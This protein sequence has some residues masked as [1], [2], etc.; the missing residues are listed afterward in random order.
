MPSGT[1]SGIRTVSHI[2]N[3]QTDQLLAIIQ[4]ISTVRSSLIDFYA[5]SDVAQPLVLKLCDTLSELNKEKRI[6]ID[7]LGWKEN[8]NE[9]LDIHFHNLEVMNQDFKNSE[10]TF[11]HYREKLVLLHAKKTT[12]ERGKFRALSGGELERLSRVRAFFL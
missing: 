8:H 10:K 3:Y 4:N 12:A 6:E 2:C 7:S 1:T 11:A 5:D 9:H